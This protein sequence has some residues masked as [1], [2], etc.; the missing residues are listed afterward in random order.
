[1]KSIGQRV[2]RVI[3]WII[4]SHY[5]LE[6]AQ[7]TQLL[8]KTRDHLEN[9]QILIHCLSSTFHHCSKQNKDV[10]KIVYEKVCESFMNQQRQDESKGTETRGELSFLCMYLYLCICRNMC[11]MIREG[12]H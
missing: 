3:G 7:N 2:E 8:L 10:L 1:M 12:S 5:Y 4:D 9:V 6:Q 11:E